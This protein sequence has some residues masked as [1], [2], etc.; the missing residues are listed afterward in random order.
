MTQ[1]NLKKENFKETLIKKLLLIG[2]HTV[3]MPEIEEDLAKIIERGTAPSI[4][5]LY[6]MKG[7]ESQCHENSANCWDANRDRSSIMTGYALLDGMW[8][9]HTW[10]LDKEKTIVETTTPREAYFG[11]ELTPEE[12][13][14]FY[15]DNAW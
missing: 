8:V 6:V 11:F 4:N 3:T 7:R 1:N 13:D 2:G 14:Q 5:H 12:A 10:V 9:Q 15:F